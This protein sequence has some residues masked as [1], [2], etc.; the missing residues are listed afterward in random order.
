M[1]SLVLF[2]RAT[3]LCAGNYQVTITDTDGCSIIQNVLILSPQPITA[4]AVVVPITCNGACNGII[5]VMGQGGTGT[6]QYQWSPPPPNGQGTNTVTGLCPD[7]WT[8]TITDTHGCDTTFTLT[9]TEPP[10]LTVGLIHTDNVCFNDCV[11]TAHIEVAGGVPP[12]TIAWTDPGGAVIDQDVVD[13]LGLCGGTY[14]VMVTDSRG[15]FVST[16]FTIATGAPI[17]AN[18]T[19]L[20]ESC[21]GPC[22]GSASVSPT[23]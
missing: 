4:T 18:L 12:Y 13:V 9:L 5:T 11:A 14:N 15:C 17:E 7:A 3:D 19:F 10:A 21:H 20:G 6:L 8:V 23:G 2:L 1:A 22:D 16:P